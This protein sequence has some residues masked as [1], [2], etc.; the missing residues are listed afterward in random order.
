MGAVM[1]PT[2]RTISRRDLL[3]RAGATRQE[4][5]GRRVK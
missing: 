3:Q 5:G 1:N 4:W 2:G